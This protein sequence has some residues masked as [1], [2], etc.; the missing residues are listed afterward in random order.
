MRT[1]VDSNGWAR[2]LAALAS[3]SSM[4]DGSWWQVRKTRESAA[5]PGVSS[6]ADY[7]VRQL[8]AQLHSAAPPIEQMLI[9]EGVAAG[10]VGIPLA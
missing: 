1:S 2:S 5:L 7:S 3:I 6:L 10:Q 8:E 4:R 9:K